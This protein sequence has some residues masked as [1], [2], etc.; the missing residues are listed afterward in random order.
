MIGYFITAASIISTLLYG[1]KSLVGPISGALL[2]VVW[3][4]YF[5]RTKQKSLLLCPVF[6]LLVHL[7]NWYLWTR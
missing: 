5:Y 4:A 1:Q 7:W 6:F 3:F 2:Q